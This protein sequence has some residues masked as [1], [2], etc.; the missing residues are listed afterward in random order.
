MQITGTLL[1]LVSLTPVEN[2]IGYIQIN[3]VLGDF[4]WKLGPRWVRGARVEL[5][6]LGGAESHLAAG[7]HGNGEEWDGIPQCWGSRQAWGCI[8]VSLVGQ[9]CHS[10]SWTLQAR[11]GQQHL[12]LGGVMLPA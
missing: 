12:R 1:A 10:L 8:W 5:G 4:S 7:A 2:L 11:W 6:A 3:L 9:G